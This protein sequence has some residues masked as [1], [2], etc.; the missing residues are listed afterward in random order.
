MKKYLSRIF[1]LIF[2]MYPVF[3]PSVCIA[4]SFTNVVYIDAYDGDT[5]TVNLKDLPD[6]FGKSIPVRISHIDAAELKT[7]NPCELKAAIKARELIRELLK[8]SKTITLLNVKRDKYFR[9]LADVDVDGV[10]LASKL[11]E[12]KFAYPYEGGTKKKI[13]WCSITKSKSPH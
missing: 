12:V 2:V 13:K 1:L 10:N 6:I 11:L 7:N 5:F 3:D 9:I 4:A 8:N